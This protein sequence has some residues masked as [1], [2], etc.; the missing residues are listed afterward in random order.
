[1]S[2][3]EI[4]SQS[5]GKACHP[6][7]VNL[8]IEWVFKVLSACE[9]FAKTLHEIHSRK[10][11]WGYSYRSKSAT[12]WAHPTIVGFENKNCRL[13]AGVTTCT[14]RGIGPA[15]WAQQSD[16]DA[17]R[18]TFLSDCWGRVARRLTSD[19]LR[20]VGLRGKLVALAAN[21]GR[22]H[23]STG[24]R[25]RFCYLIPLLVINVAGPLG[26]APGAGDGGTVDV[27]SAA[28]GAVRKKNCPSLRAGS[29]MLPY[30]GVCRSLYL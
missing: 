6:I 19:G 14:C 5:S 15:K 23:L 24:I 16:Q 8:I 26:V 28:A 27:T 2:G 12:L 20:R 13:V 25:S 17:S 11:E 29:A 3:P 7:R 21:P 30:C 18:E 4:C 1:M 9:W 22:H 10:N